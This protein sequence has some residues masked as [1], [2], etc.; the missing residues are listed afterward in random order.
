MHTNAT[1]L[2][3][4]GIIAILAVMAGVAWAGQWYA[5]DAVDTLRDARIAARK[6]ALKAADDRA[7]LALMSSAAAETLDERTRLDAMTHADVVSA[8][9]LIE[10]AGKG[11][12]AVVRVSDVAPAADRDPKLA[13][14]TG[15]HA[16]IFSVDARGSFAQV[17]AALERLE[18][19]PIPV[20]IEQ[21][22]LATDTDTAAKGGRWHL[23]ARLRLLSAVAS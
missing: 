13:A 12:G 21:F 10:S 7:N 18:T 4:A 20:Q 3:H 2:R 14:A 23:T 6:Q 1:K 16:V 9:A 19:L 15:V 11:T 5:Q 17:F 22:S 8:A